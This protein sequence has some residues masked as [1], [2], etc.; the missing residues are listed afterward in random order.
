MVALRTIRIADA[1]FSGGSHLSTGV[2]Q[3]GVRQLAIQFARLAAAS[4]TDLTD[5]GTGAAAD[6]TMGEVPVPTAGYT[7]VATASAPK[8]G[9]E[10]ALGLI[11]DALTELA[12][13]IVNVK[14]LIPCSDLVN[15]I[16]GAAP[17]L[18]IAAMTK[19]VTAA[20]SSIVAFSTG[21]ILMKAYRDYLFQLAI[22]T[23]RVAAAC[24]QTPLIISGQLAEQVA[25]P[26]PVLGT[27]TGT[28]VSG[29]LASGVSKVSADAFLTALADGVKEISTVLNACTGGT[30]SKQCYTVAA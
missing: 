30:A 5:N 7:D 11:R 15:N 13:Q 3:D 21:S 14:A 10:T 17:D 20:S 19:T 1:Y 22:E 28:A 18:T 16:G 29:T 12:G 27:D 6:G 23:N 4:L 25:S 24:G 8:A 26:L 9:F 2:L